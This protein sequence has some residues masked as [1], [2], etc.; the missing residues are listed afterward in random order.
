MDGDLSSPKP[1]EFGPEKCWETKM[2][3]SL[4]EGA[5][6]VGVSKNRG[7]TPK[8]DGEN[9]EKPYEQMDDLGENP[10]FLETPRCFLVDFPCK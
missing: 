10:L 3:L 9:N 1:T 4:Q 5:W 7:K 2:I 8:M 6:Q